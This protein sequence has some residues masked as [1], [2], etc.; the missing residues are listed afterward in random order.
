[1]SL[2]TQWGYTLPNI[3]SLPSMLDV[4]AFDEFTA[5]KYSGDER[6]ERNLMAASTAIRNYCGWHVSPSLTCTLSTTLHDKRVVRVGHALLIQLPATYVSEVSS[7]EINGTAYTLFVIE[8]NGML[9]VYGIDFAGFY[10]YTTIE[11]TYTAGVP[12]ALMESVEELIAHRATHA[13]ASS[14]G[15]QSEAAGGVSITYSANWIN[16]SMST[17]LA[18]DNK[19]V[20]APFKLEGV[21]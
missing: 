17:A 16:S 11:I 13:L 3:E 18:D 14:A 2:L 19:E 6:I 7:I 21:F 5:G 8:P 9:K 20:L 4:A 12:S 10:E 15:V 1:M